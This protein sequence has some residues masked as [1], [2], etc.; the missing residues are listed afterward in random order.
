MLFC[1]M[2]W[3]ICLLAGPVLAAHAQKNTARV[4][5]KWKIEDVVRSFS[6]KNDTVYV[7]NF[8][9][10]FCKP[11][12]EEIPDF[13]RIADQYKTKKVKLLLVSL[14]LPSYVP[15][16]LPEFIKKNKFNTNHV[17]LNETNA[18]HF[19]PMI[20]PKW[21]GAIPS[22]IIVNNRTGYKKFT[23]DQISAADFEKYIQEAI[24]GQ[25]MN[26][27]VAPMNDAIVNDDTIQRGAVYLSKE[28]IT[29][30]SKD[31]SVYS[32]AEGKVSYIARIEGMKVV[33]IKDKEH[34]YTYANL[35]STAV[36]TGDIIKANQLI[37]FAAFD[38][39]GYKPTLE[40]YKTD[41]GGTN[42]RL[43][44]KDFTVRKGKE[45]VRQDA[46]AVK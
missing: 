26:R 30:K 39:D 37:G 25:A 3:L 4:I 14:D 12:I 21:S 45:P 2:A 11:C 17:W 10:T 16:R 20:D 24:G 29:F 7:I 44:K 5:P 32:V 33:I 13:I 9:A 28:Y 19:C 23:E 36:K 41:N 43:S 38:L 15:V 46:E 27:Y 6:G 34:F 22:T 35:G 1:R 42:L 40:L 18:D 31:S 8:W